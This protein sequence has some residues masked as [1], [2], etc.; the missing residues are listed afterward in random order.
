MSYVYERKRSYISVKPI[1][2][3]SVNSFYGSLTLFQLAPYIE[4]LNLNKSKN[5]NIEEIHIRE[6]QRCHS[7]FTH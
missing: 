6:T 5:I 1:I 4:A 7:S 2:K 3:L